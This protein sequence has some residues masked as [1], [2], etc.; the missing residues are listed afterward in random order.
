MTTVAEPPLFKKPLLGFRYW[1]LDLNNKVLLSVTSDVPW[2]PGV[3]YAAG[4]S[5]HSS[6]GLNCACGFNAWY[7]LSSINNLHYDYGG[8]GAVAG[9]I[10]GTGTMAIHPTGFRSSEAQVLALLSSEKTNDDQRD[11]IKEIAKR[12]SV[13]VFKD[14]NELLLFLEN[15]DL[16]NN[17]NSKLKKI[18]PKAEYEEAFMAPSPI[19]ADTSSQLESYMKALVQNPVSQPEP[20]NT[21][22]PKI[23]K[24][25]SKFF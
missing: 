22:K 16:V 1:T 9:A 10:A 6:P 25:I 8:K 15:L 20:A 7:D 17:K 23:W 14:K 24:N 11:L 12:Y 19:N 13:P 2:Q 21:K 5:N 4:C 3:N 18:I